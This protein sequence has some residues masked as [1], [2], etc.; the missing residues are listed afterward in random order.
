VTEGF[1]NGSIDILVHIAADMTMVDSS[2]FITVNIM[3][4]G[5]IL[6]DE[7]VNMVI[8]AKVSS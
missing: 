4:F 2:Y 7:S 1:Q 6:A 3:M 8:K 5:F